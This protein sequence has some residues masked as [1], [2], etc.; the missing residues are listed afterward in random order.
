M[1]KR[2]VLLGMP[3]SGKSSIGRAVAAQLKCRFID[4]DQMIEQRTGMTIP[5]LFEKKGE[6]TFRK[7]EEILAKKL[8]QTQNVVISTGGG[9]VTRP[10]SIEALANEESYVI[11][12][13]RSFYK[14][15]STPQGIINRRPLLREKSASEFHAMYKER[16]P[17]Y[18]KYCTVEVKNETEREESVRDILEKVR[19]EGIHFSKKGGTL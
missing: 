19:E 1:Y 9:I 18:R 14:L 6:A 7:L 15:V 12:L 8:G 10:E 13:Y 2:I 16:M 5:E 4:M 3:C 11:F 17:L